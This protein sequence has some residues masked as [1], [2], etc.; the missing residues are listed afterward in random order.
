VQ[1]GHGL[2]TTRQREII[3]DELRKSRSHPT[4]D[5]MYEMVRRRLPRISLGT[6]YRNLEVLS[7]CGMIRKLE[8]GGT[9]KRFDGIAGAHYH[10]LCTRCGRIEDLPL[11]AMPEISKALGRKKIRDF[12]IREHRVAFLGLCPKCRDGKRRLTAVSRGATKG[13]M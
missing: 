6:V 5:E 4:A 11:D 7:D 10:L 3:M 9:Q 8:I 13:G 2:R 12:E 1:S